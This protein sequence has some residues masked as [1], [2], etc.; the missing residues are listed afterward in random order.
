MAFSCINK[1]PVVILWYR[2]PCTLSCSIRWK[3][4]FFPA[5]SVFIQVSMTEVK[6]LIT[7]IPSFKFV[8]KKAKIFNKM[9]NSS[10]CHRKFITLWLKSCNEKWSDAGISHKMKT[11]LT[12]LSIFYTNYLCFWSVSTLQKYRLN[13]GSRSD[14]ST[15]GQTK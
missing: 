9:L 10:G 13:T 5:H 12:Q 6:W 11:Y 1:T 3:N 14:Q 15:L 8:S 7:H 4:P 2:N